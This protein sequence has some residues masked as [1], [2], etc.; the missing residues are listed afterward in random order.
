M[1]AERA[2]K[3]TW[4]S[5]LPPHL[6][7]HSEPGGFEGLLSGA[8]NRAVCRLIASLQRTPMITVQ[9]EKTAAELEAD[10]KAAVAAGQWGPAAEALLLFDDAGIATR[11]TKL[12]RDQLIWLHTAALGPNHRRV[13]DAITKRDREAAYQACLRTG[14]WADVAT[15]LDGFDNAGIKTRVD[16]LP[17][18]QVVLLLAAVP[19]TMHRVRAAA[20]D[21]QWRTAVAA[22][23]WA[24]ACTALYGFNDDDIK[25]RLRALTVE[26]ILALRAVAASNPRLMALIEIGSAN[27]TNTTDTGNAYTSNAMVLRNGVLITKEVKFVSAGTFAAGKF[28]ALRDR[29]VAAVT[30]YMT[31]KYKLR[32]GPPGGGAATGDGDY[33]ITVRVVPSASA[34]YQVTLHGGIQGRSAMASGGGNVYERGQGSETSVPDIVLAHE[35]SHMILGAS[36]EYANASVPGRVITTDNSLMGNFYSQGIAAAHLKAR[37]L[38]FLT[39][40]AATWFPGRTITI[41]K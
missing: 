35:S 7:H 5:P 37:N 16:A 30:S 31:G 34:T 24:A 40:L 29:V 2:D 27:F 33:P 13:L 12:G 38:Q 39:T 22:G 26:Q 14:R 20:L 9:R 18:A 4:K 3:P 21:I 17:A 41:V 25:T 1:G 23:Q 11:L 10:W 28:D 32:V 19:A 8:G 6:T 36:D 15:V